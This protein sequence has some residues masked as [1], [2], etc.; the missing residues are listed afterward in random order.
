MQISVVKK[1]GIIFLLFFYFVQIFAQN[2][3]SPKQGGKR[4]IQ[5]RRS[6]RR[7]AGKLLSS[8]NKQI[9]LKADSIKKAPVMVTTDT[10]AHQD[11]LSSVFALNDSLRLDSLKRDSLNKVLAMNLQRKHEQDTASYKAIMPIAYLPFNK[12]PLFMTIKVKLPETKDALFYLLVGLVFVVAVIRLTFPKY[13]NTLLLLAFQTKFRQRQTKEMLV[14]DNLASLAMNLLFFINGGLYISLIAQINGIHPVGF[15]LLFLYA[16]AILS[17]IYAVKFLFLL[18]VGWVFNAKEA[19]NTYLFIVFM[20]NKI[21]GI[22]LVPFLLLMSF[23][24][25]PI[26][27]ISITVSMIL[28]GIMLLYRYLVSLGSIRHDLKVNALHFFLYLCAVEILPLL[29]MYKF[30]FNYFGNNI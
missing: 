10:I 23:S 4:T 29:L 5:L 2:A 7:N 6:V 17:I 25:S 16:A 15:W 1:A 14:Q 22:L 27:E 12:Q 26:P 20:C 19:A 28:V 11:S 18:F 13:F 21:V 30:I 9:H 24:S 8:R 3:D